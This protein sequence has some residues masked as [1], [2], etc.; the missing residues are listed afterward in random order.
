MSSSQQYH[1]YQKI[2]KTIDWQDF[3]SFQEVLEN[4]VLP[5]YLPHR[6]WFRS[7]TKTIQTIKVDQYP[8]L[9][10]ETDIVYLLCVHAQY[11]DATQ[12][13]YLLPIMLVTSSVEIGQYLQHYPQAII[14]VAQHQDTEGVI[15]DASYSVTFQKALFHLLQQQ[16][17]LENK[18][19]KLLFEAGSALVQYESKGDIQSNILGVEQTN[20]SIIYNDDFFLKIYRKL[21]SG[22]NSDL[23][24][25]RFLSEKTDFKNAPQYGGGITFIQDGAEPVVVGLMQNKINNVGDAWNT[26]LE[27]VAGYYERVIAQKVNRKPQLMR[28]D[29]LYFMDMP[30]DMRNLIGR[31]TYQRVVQLAQRTAEMHLALAQESDD[32][33]FKPHPFDSIQ[34]QEISKNHIELMNDKLADLANRIPEFSPQIALEAQMVLSYRDIIIHSLQTFANTAVE[35]TQIRVHG[36]YHLG[37]VLDNG[38]DFYIIDFEGEPMRSMEARRVKSTPFKDV[39]GMIRSFHYAAYGQLYLNAHQYE[40]QQIN[41]LEQW[42]AYWFHY[43]SQFYLTAYLDRVEHQSFVPKDKK[44]LA[45]LIRTFVLEK[46]IYELGYEM[47]ARPDWLRIPLRGVLH[48]IEQSKSTASL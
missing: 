40:P 14:C 3:V 10:M 31:N 36:D 11:T 25:V 48:E 22:I 28:K 8:N 32:P 45:L 30:V 7:K 23:E 29:R 6:R 4:T 1:P 47:N 21:E 24:L 34:Q 27:K 37:Q 18:K 44:S 9:L 20:S 43:I 38:K 17:I 26:M 16:A 46:A 13:D 35:A 2:E 41:I 15:I 19:G 12:E 33:A 42:A 5:S 39:A